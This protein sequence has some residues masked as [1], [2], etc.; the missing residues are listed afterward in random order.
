M[1]PTAAAPKSPLAGERVA[2]AIGRI[3]GSWVLVAGPSSFILALVLLNTT[4]L[5]Q[6]GAQPFDPR[7]Y[8]LLNLI[9]SALAALQAPV[10]MMFLNR[11][12]R[13]DRDRAEHDA[14]MSL[15]LDR[16]IGAL[17]DRIDTLRERELAD[18]LAHQI[19]LLQ[20]LRDRPRST[21]A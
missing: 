14:E 5:L 10:V 21:A 15:K 16:E 17:H 7:P 3:A 19:E 20:E 13:R 18:L 11:Q 12:A 8:L 2:E 6:S 9:L 1:D 4:F